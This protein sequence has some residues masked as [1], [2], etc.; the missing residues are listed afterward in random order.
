M[1]GPGS[2]E[3]RLQVCPATRLQPRRGPIPS[4]LEFFHVTVDGAPTGPW[5]LSR[6]RKRLPSWSSDSEN[7]DSLNIPAAVHSDAKT[8]RATVRQCSPFILKKCF[9]IGFIFIII[10]CK[11]GRKDKVAILNSTKS[12]CVREEVGLGSNARLYICSRC[13]LDFFRKSV[14]I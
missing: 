3:S 13:F 12:L 7:S 5:I 1:A 14:K 8:T 11:V 6:L 10:P 9:N 4:H 2:P